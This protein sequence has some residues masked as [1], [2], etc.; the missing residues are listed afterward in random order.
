MDSL[1]TEE[2]QTSQNEISEKS[3][4]FPAKL[5]FTTL[6]NQKQCILTAKFHPVSVILPYVTFATLTHAHTIVWQT[7][8]SHCLPDFLPPLVPKDIFQG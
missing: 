8:S 4:F 7:W 1:C 5:L 2:R 3:W 6:L